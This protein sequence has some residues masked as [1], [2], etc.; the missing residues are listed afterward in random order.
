LGQVFDIARREW[1]WITV[2]PT[3]DVKKPPPKKSRPKVIPYP[4]IWGMVEALGTAHKSRETALAFL[5]GIETAMRPTELF[6]LEPAQVDFE[7]QTAHLDET[8]NGDE[9]DVPLSTLACMW[10]LELLWMNGDRFFTVTA[11]SASTLWADARKTTPYAGL[12]FRHSRRE[13]ISR[14][15]KRLDILELARASGHRDLKSLMIY[16][17]ADA[18]AMARKLP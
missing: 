7:A 15:S 3:K 9:R 13:G 16:Y 1:K 12:H 4:A 8:K 10:L 11:A 18:A 5:V 2:D 6:S 17:S 14:L